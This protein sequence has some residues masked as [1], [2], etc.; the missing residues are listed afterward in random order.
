MSLPGFLLVLVNLTWMALVLSVVCARYRDFPQMVTSLLQIIFYLTPIVW[1][2][3]LL[4]QRAS[5]YMLD[6]NPFYH[7]LELM[8]APLLG[9]YPSTMNWSVGLIMALVGWGF[10]VLF[11]QRYKQRIAFWL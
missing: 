2:P 3:S 7:L 8:R 5:F 11:Y 1:M 6:L 10:A 9:Q 4:P